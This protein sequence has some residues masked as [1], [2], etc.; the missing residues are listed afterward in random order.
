[1]KRKMMQFMLLTSILIEEF[2]PIKNEGV[3]PSSVALCV[4]M[5][6]YRTFRGDYQKLVDFVHWYNEYS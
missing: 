5:T 6:D 3:Q 4:S 2:R 1:M